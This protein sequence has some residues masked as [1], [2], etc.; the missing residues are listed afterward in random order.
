VKVE[1]AYAL[2]APGTKDG[3]TKLVKEADGSVWAYGWD[4]TK[5]E[6]EKIG[7]VVA[8]PEP[9]GGGEG[10][11]RLVKGDRKLGIRLEALRGCLTDTCVLC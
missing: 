9:G 8:A 6:W 11:R 4:A 5:A 2:A 10:G 3:E 1:D 7:E